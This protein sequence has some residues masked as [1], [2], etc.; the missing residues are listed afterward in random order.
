MAAVP[1]NEPD[2]NAT[3]NALWF[4]R[5]EP[6]VLAGAVD[7]DASVREL[8]L[9]ALEISRNPRLFEFAAAQ[10]E[11]LDPLVRLLG[12][13][14]LRKVDPQH[15]V[16]VI[17][18]LLDDPDL[19]VVAGAE[20]ALMRWSGEDSGV[21]T[22]LSIPT[23]EANHPSRVDPA[24]VEI[25]QRGVERRKA[26]WNLHAKDYPAGPQKLP[27]VLQLFRYECGAVDQ[28]D[29]SRT[30]V[31]PPSYLSVSCPRP[32]FEPFSGRPEPHSQ[33]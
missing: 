7:G 30:N 9:A 5:A 21:R 18:R 13:D 24:N 4:A 26:W 31:R 33:H 22:R 17:I 12:L 20:I 6:L 29:A 2:D 8:S 28:F 15:A 10:L 14:Y 25:I 32:V 19:R 23:P 3:S 27:G 16:P 11:D 1:G